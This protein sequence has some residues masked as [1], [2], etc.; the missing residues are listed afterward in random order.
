MAVLV[1]E[2][3]LKDTARLDNPHE[4]GA[5]LL[6]A[7]IGEDLLDRMAVEGVDLHQMAEVV[8]CAVE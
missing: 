6:A 2:E 1:H 4:V 5:I 8:L 3:D 7:D